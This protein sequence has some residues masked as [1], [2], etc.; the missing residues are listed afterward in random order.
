MTTV[1]QKWRKKVATELDAIRVSS[2][3]G[4]LSPGVVLNWAKEHP[5]SEMY[6]HFEWNNEKASHEYR[7]WQARQ[8][9]TTYVIVVDDPKPE[10]QKRMSVKLY[11]VPGR[12][13]KKEAEGSYVSRDV[14]MDTPSY[15]EGILINQTKLL[16]TMRKNYGWLTELSHVWDAIDV[17]PDIEEEE[18]A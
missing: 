12:R 15:R 14:V 2:G 10:G 11:S 9:I 1:Q 7:L 4:S 18:A 13:G 5:N 3:D 16:K 17:T 6:K 8:M